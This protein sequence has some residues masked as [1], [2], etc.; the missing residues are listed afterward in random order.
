MNLR[1]L[2]YFQSVAETL[3]F[4]KAAKMNGI[5]Q[6]PL[7]Q[8]IS[9]LERELNV[10]LFS[11]RS[12]RKI[13]LTPAGEALL[14]YV[15]RTLNAAANIPLVAQAHSKGT[16]G[17]IVM[18]AT[19]TALLTIVPRIIQDLKYR[20]LN[21]EIQAESLTGRQQT[22]ALLDGT[23]DIGIFRG[24]INHADL[25][26]E[27][28]FSEP[29]VA[30]IPSGHHLSSNALVTAD[31]LCAEDIIVGAPEDGR[32]INDIAHAF[33]SQQNRI[34]V[35]HRVAQLSTAIA[36]VRAGLGIALVPASISEINIDGVIYRSL[37]ETAPIIT[38]C[39][40]SHRETLGNVVD[41]IRMSAFKVSSGLMRQ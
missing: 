23:I 25:I 3:N 32:G 5:A 15:R 35:R 1:Q 22:A 16:T 37:G 18:G 20:G 12:T 34:N 28:L 33:F 31:Q 17:R 19:F 27:T 7:S 4:T 10:Q 11:R 2:Q 13:S 36:L 24:P 26:S 41:Q 6:P 29:F 40:V 8:Q 14:P 9:A 38:V 39:I 30:A 21:I